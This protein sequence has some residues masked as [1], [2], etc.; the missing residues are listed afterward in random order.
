MISSSVELGLDKT[1]K[2][3]KIKKA[4]L[5][6]SNSAIKKAL[7]IEPTNTSQNLMLTL[8]F[9]RYLMFESDNIDY[10]I[11]HNNNAIKK[12]YSMYPGF[13]FSTPGFHGL[14]LFPHSLVNETSSWE[15][16]N[17]IVEYK[18]ECFASKLSEDIERLEYVEDF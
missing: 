13:N 10:L 14:N 6:S 12:G 17:G 1:A 16:L 8:A 15:I 7:T 18:L 4:L 3:Y 11:V 5:R 2:Y 9:G